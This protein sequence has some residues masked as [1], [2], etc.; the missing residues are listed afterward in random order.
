MSVDNTIREPTYTLITSGMS[1]NEFN[2]YKAEGVEPFNMREY[3]TAL[4][5]GWIFQNDDEPEEIAVVGMREEPV[6][7][8]RRW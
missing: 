7:Y 6:I 2:E 3:I 5:N 8:L 1:L 4:G